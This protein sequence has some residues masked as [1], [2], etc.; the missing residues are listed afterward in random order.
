MSAIVNV[1]EVRSDEP[2]A[3]H[4]RENA[5]TLAA[6]DSKILFLMSNLLLSFVHFILSIKPSSRAAP[7]NGPCLKSR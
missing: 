7:K 5:N 3:L 1:Q 2:A 4:D 6:A